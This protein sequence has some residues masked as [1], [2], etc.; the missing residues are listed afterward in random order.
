MDFNRPLSPPTM[1]NV[2]RW[3]CRGQS[4]IYTSPA[5]FGGGQT[6]SNENQGHITVQEYLRLPLG[7]TYG[8]TVYISVLV[9]PHL[10]SMHPDLFG[11]ILPG[12]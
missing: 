8:F 5:A 10:I 7:H 2:G 9:N 6:H 12:R 1:R 4:S 3:G 11:L